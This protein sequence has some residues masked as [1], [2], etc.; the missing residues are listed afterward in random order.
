MHTIEIPES[1]K[2]I[3]LPSSWSECSREQLEF[4]LPLAYKT[5]IGQV[6]LTDFY[7][8]SFAFV[9]GFKPS[10]KTEFA[11]RFNPVFLKEINA[12]LIVLAEK[13]CAWPFKAID[14]EVGSRLELAIETHVN[15]FP[16]IGNLI[17][18]ADLI[19][20]LSFSEFRAAIREMDAYIHNSKDPELLNDAAEA[21]DRF[22]AILYTPADPVTG[23]RS[24]A[25][26]EL[27]HLVEVLKIEPWRKNAI[28]L[29]FSFCIKYIQTEEI[30]IDGKMINLSAIF[31]RAAAGEKVADK[32]LGWAGLLFDL[33]KEGPFGKAQETDAAGLFDVLL[34]LY[35]NYL[36][37]IKLQKRLKS[38]K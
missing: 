9:T 24:K 12:N 33:S 30:I 1:N 22:V 26:Q 37:N 32:G 2:T 29:W 28:L 25:D 38:K 19:A 11:K 34:Y 10:V 13:L 36:D 35:K 15:L 16:S 5:A 14:T 4:L 3:T 31:P 23:K 7:L 17:G 27:K 21:L 6:E 8:Q 20:D 18:P